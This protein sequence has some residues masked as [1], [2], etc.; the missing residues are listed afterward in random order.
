MAGYWQRPDETAKVMTADG[1]FKTGDIGVRGRAR[2]LQ[3]RRPQEGH[4]PGLRLQRVPERDRGRGRPAAP[5]CSNAPW[6]AC[7]DEKTGE[8]V[9]LV[10]VKK[11]PDLTEEQVREYC[12]ANLTGY[13]QPQGDRVPHRAAQDAGRQ[14]PAPR[15]ARQEVRSRP[16]EPADPAWLVHTHAAC[17]IPP[18]APV[19]DHPDL[20]RDDAAGVL[21]DPAGAGRPDRD[22][23]RRARHRRRRAT[24]QLLKEY[25]LDQPLLVQYGIYIGR[26][27]HGDLGKSIITQ[28]PVMQR[29]PGAVPG[30]HRAGGLR[31][32][33]RA[34]AGHSG[35][36][37]RGGASATRC[38]TTA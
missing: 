2:L 11:N 14:D 32:P 15:T 26:V 24:P 33:V 7:A 38:S 10:I 4:D 37:H 31:H 30:H 19:A 12:R 25:G 9:K 23:G 29:V 28:E 27:L 17:S 13:K 22:P 36:H 16:V 3:D 1:Y 35:R 5:A 34:A 8:A 21:P 20:H 18:D 6:S